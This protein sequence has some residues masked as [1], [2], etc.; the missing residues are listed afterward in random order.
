MTL[1][2]LRKKYIGKRFKVCSGGYKGLEGVCYS[3]DGDW[4]LLPSGPKFL[5][6]FGIRKDNGKTYHFPPRELRPLN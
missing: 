6:S 1:E 5:L 2:E 3:I 4:A